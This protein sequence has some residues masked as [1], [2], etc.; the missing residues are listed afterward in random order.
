MSENPLENM[1]DRAAQC[2]RMASNVYDDEVKRQLRQWAEE[3][4]A[5]IKQ[6]EAALG[7]ARGQGAS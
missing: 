2:R 3:I 1:R 4:E 7:C 6:L 5:D